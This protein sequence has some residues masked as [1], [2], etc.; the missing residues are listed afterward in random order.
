MREERFCCALMDRSLGSLCLERHSIKVP[1]RNATGIATHLQFRHGREIAEK[2]PPRRRKNGESRAREA[3]RTMRF[4]ASVDNRPSRV[5]R[6]NI[7]FEDMHLRPQNCQFY[8]LRSRRFRG[9]RAVG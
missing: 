4:D 1:F 3:A 9:L 2:C 6:A 8:H 7:I 5:Y